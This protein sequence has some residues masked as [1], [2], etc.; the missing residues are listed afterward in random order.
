[1]R[2]IVGLG[3]PGVA[4]NKTRHN[5]GFWFIEALVEAYGGVKVSYPRIKASCYKI[6]V[7]SGV[8]FAMMPLT[9]M[10]DSGGAVAGLLRYHDIDPHALMIVHDELDF[11]VGKCRLKFSGGHGGHNGVRDVIRC[12][13]TSDFWRLRIGIDKN[14]SGN[15]QHS[16]VLGVMPNEQ[17]EQTM[18]SIVQLMDHLPLL[19]QG[20][21]ET[22]MNQMHES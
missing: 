9:F 10:N 5:V 12:L 14:H 4:Y 11:P 2:C 13:G 3:N 8:L 7:E 21:Y 6:H 19:C 17:H 16:H 22:V 18:A 1:M 15:K 20:Q